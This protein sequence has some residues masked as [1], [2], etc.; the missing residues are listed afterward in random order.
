MNIVPAVI[1]PLLPFVK[2]LLADGGFAI[3]SGIIG[4]YLNDTKI[5]IKTCGLKI[6]EKTTENDWQCIVAEK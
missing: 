4:Q 1:I 5:A 3:L 2:D 6:I